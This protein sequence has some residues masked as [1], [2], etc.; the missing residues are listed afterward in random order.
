MKQLRDRKTLYGFLRRPS[1]LLQ[2]Y[3]NCD[4]LYRIID[5]LRIIYDCSFFQKNKKIKNKIPVTDLNR[6]L[7]SPMF[8][9]KS[10]TAFMTE[11]L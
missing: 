9:Y 1:D 5:Y 2:G 10:R 8:G 6:C 11:P 3:N 4:Y 7:S